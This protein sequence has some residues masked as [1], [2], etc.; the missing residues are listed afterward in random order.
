M[1]AYDGNGTRLIITVQADL[2]GL[3]QQWSTTVSMQANQFAADVKDQLMQMLP[4]LPCS[5]FNLSDARFV[6]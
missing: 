4:K 3:S 1:K 2:K 5:H 6:K